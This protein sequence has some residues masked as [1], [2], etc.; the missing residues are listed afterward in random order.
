MILSWSVYDIQDM[1]VE[2]IMLSKSCGY[3]NLLWI[4]QWWISRLVPP[5]LDVQNSEIFYCL[6]VWLYYMVFY[7]SNFSQ[8]I[9][10]PQ[11]F[12]C[13]LPFFIRII[14]FMKNLFFFRNNISN[15]LRVIVV[16][17]E[18]FFEMQLREIVAIE[19]TNKLNNAIV[20]KVS[21]RCFV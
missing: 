15:L 21:N 7:Y 6:K 5:S 12:K 9:L 8:N 18:L 3:I 13:I 14:L 2:D 1:K 11:Y 17:Q 19:G 16:R 10:L 20:H 4:Y